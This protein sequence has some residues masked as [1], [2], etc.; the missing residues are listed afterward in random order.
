MQNRIIILI[1]T[2][3]FTYGIAMGQKQP[4]SFQKLLYIA[5]SDTLPYGLREPLKIT[6]NEKY[7]LV[8]FLHGAGERGKDNE[9]Q[10]KHI[11]IMFNHNTLNKYP[12]FVLAPQCPE[13]QMWSDIASGKLSATPTRP[14]QL[15]IDLLEEILRDYPIDPKRIYITGVSMGGFGTWDLL[16]RFPQRFA[17]AVPICGGG[18]ERTAEKIKHIPMWVFHGAEDEVVSPKHS[19]RMVT[20]IQNAGGSPGYT[21]YPGIKHNSWTTAYKEPHLMPWLFRQTLQ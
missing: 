21:E 8:I 9:K 4:L 13:K 3:T 11:Q 14:M 20:A 16:A 10:V 17:A 1:I 12:S 6:P 18:D 19:R 7:P 2:I 15:F 5:N